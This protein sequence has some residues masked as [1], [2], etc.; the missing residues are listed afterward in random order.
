MAIT[1]YTH[2]TYL[3]QHFERVFEVAF[4][5]IEPFCG[6]GSVNDSVVAA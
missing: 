2:S 5:Y 6:Y 3:D 1:V 4:E